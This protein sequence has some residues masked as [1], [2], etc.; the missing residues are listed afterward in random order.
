[1]VSEITK[2]GI[3]ALKSGDRARAHQL[4]L[5]AVQHDP[6]DSLA[7]LWLS[8]AVE[9]DAERMECLK[10]V[11]AINPDHAA[12]RRGLAMLLTKSR[13]S[14]DP[15]DILI[16]LTDPQ[17]EAVLHQ[18][19][20]LLIIAGPGSG[21]TEVIARRVAYM[22]RSGIVRP[23]QILAVTFTE[24]AA[25]GL[26]DRIQRRL[27]EVNAERMQVSTI[28]S[29]A[30]QLLRQYSAQSPLP[31]GFRLLD[32][33]GQFL[34][35]YS[36]RN[37]LGLSEIV[38]GRPEDFF[39]A[40][41]AVFNLAT[42]ELVTPEKLANC[43]NEQMAKAGE[44]E[45]DLCKEREIIA[46]A[47]GRYCKLLQE[48]A[49]IDFAFL[50]R[51]AL[52]LLENNPE[53]VRELREEYTAILVDEYQDTNAAQE[54]IIASL[55][56]DGRNLTV[57]GDDDQSI[58]RFRGATV[59]NILNFP[60]R[61]PN[62]HEVVLTH[63]FRSWEPILDHSLL[64]IN[65]NPARFPKDLT[66]VRGPG[67]EVL[68]V[69]EHSTAEEAQAVVRLIRRLHDARRIDHYGD[70]VILLRSVKSYAEP[71]IQALSLEGIPYQVIG[72]ASLFEKEEV[73]QLYDLFNFLTTAKAWGDKY[74]RDPIVGLS[75]SACCA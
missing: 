21:K 66:A 68:L 38:K 63:N 69:Y 57:V 26:K 59:K 32:E 6:N 31:R 25:Q 72:D 29:F 33:T 37:L 50:Q 51:H 7:W 39:A 1:M 47:Y 27:P 46:E 65:Q 22:V 8:G 19:S 30:S 34:Y 11:L 70:V 20:P 53:I 52:S 16:G 4:L 35:V 23:E 60:E 41:I 73:A 28:H 54:R 64:V 18:G 14:M 56:G 5:S 58:Y 3:Q 36:R 55:A 48:N 40:V 61:Y 45:I 42:E 10:R 2:Q 9:S 12:A 15:D 13:N 75:E 43:Y 24:R 67:N 44:K 49:L 17:K 74:L 62:T 71:Y